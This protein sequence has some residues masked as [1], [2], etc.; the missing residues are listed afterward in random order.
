MRNKQHN[1][2]REIK[3][4]RQRQLWL[5]DELKSD[6]QRTNQMV[7]EIKK[8]INKTEKT[9]QD[10]HNAIHE[11]REALAIPFTEGMYTHVHKWYERKHYMHEQSRISDTIDLFTQE[12]DENKNSITECFNYGYTL[13]DHLEE[14]KQKYNMAKYKYNM[15]SQSIEHIKTQC[16]ETNTTPTHTNNTNTESDNNFMDELPFFDH[17]SEEEDKE[18]GTEQTPVSKPEPNTSQT[19]SN[20]PTNDNNNDT[21]TNTDNNFIDAQPFSNTCGV[22]E[23]GTETEKGE[24]SN[25][26]ESLNNEIGDTLSPETKEIKN[27]TCTT[28]KIEEEENKLS[29]TTK[30]KPNKE[31]DI[32]ENNEPI[33]TTKLTRNEKDNQSSTN[34]YTNEDKHA[35]LE[36]AKL[37]VS[38]AS[39][40]TLHAM[41]L[42]FIMWK[43]ARQKYKLWNQPN[44][45]HIWPIDELERNMQPI[46]CC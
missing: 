26:N 27:K 4:D 30:Y 35:T 21:N 16:R 6:I 3:S 10:K 5:M 2:I 37:P 12:I 39:T 36:F 32:Q 25:Q 11:C 42:Q 43:H 7:E 28:E 15:L 41:I 9:I 20:N 19:E 22:D 24:T 23:E 40:V 14:Y 29:N 18:V 17:T 45:P 8:D 34:H 31:Y 38:I 46:A 33:D 44:S 13:F 1:Q